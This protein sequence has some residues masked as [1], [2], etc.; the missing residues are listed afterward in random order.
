MTAYQYRGMDNSGQ[1]VLGFMDAES[2]DEAQAKLRGQGIFVTDLSAFDP[3]VTPEWSAVSLSSP[4][5]IPSGRLLA[6][7]LPCTHEQR[8]VS[9]E[10]SLNLLGVGG[11][12]HLIL[13]RPGGGGPT[14]EL[15]V[16]TIKEVKRRGLFRKSLLVTTN[17]FEEHVF[18][19]SVGKLQGL[20]EWAL[21][22]TEK[23]TKGNR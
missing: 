14:L 2:G 11:G 13:D 23:V 10:G 1:E 21:F 20:C 19:G 15:P 18:R 6:Q 5:S 4:T 7:G 22:A 16:Q 9:N 12:L 17:T 3:E 8:G